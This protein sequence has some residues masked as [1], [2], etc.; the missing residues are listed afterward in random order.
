MSQSVSN[1][2]S[3]SA[4][5]GLWTGSATKSSG[6]QGSDSAF[7]LALST[8]IGGEAATQEG[9][10]AAQ[11]TLLSLAN[12]SENAENNAEVDLAGLLEGLVAQLEEADKESSYSGELLDM[13]QSWLQSAISFLNSTS[14]QVAEQNASNEA[15]LTLAEQPQTIRF[16]LQDVIMQLA[17]RSGTNQPELTNVTSGQATSILESLQAILTN[18]GVSAEKGT[19]D[20]NRQTAGSEFAGKL[21]NQLGLAN[22]DAKQ[23]QTTGITNHRFAADSLKTVTDTAP[24][25]VVQHVEESNPAAGSKQAVTESSLTETDG[26][27]QSGT[28]VTAGQ[29]ALRD[30]SAAALKIP[31]TQVPVEKFSEEVGK[32]IVNKLEII[33]AGGVS[34]ARISLY[35]EHLGQVDIKITMQN[36]HMVAQFVTEHLFAKESLEG[37][38]A[39][40]R[41]ALQSQGLQVNKLEV[42]QNA[43]L[44]SHMYQDGRQ[45]GNSSNLNQQHSDRRRNEIREEDLLS[46]QDLNEEWTEWMT[47]VRTREAGLGS[48]FVARV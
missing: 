29:L 19:A 48:S 40:L 1:V 46:V 11:L 18:A 5:G 8:M 14:N 13:L 32:F 22:Q 41:S 28:I 2:S 37:Q 42:T 6:T 43:G 3:N 21:V 24:L 31:A 25:Q 45:Q 39:Q 7:G 30:N 9:G 35:P 34:E 47:E 36:G 17:Q 33:K 20:R 27:I 4:L 26:W 12:S 16:A 10:L 44:S 15:L 23:L 38:M